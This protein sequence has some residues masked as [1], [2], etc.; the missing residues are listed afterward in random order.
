MI[1][2]LHDFI[3]KAELTLDECMAGVKLMPY[4]QI[5]Q[6]WTPEH[7]KAHRMPDILGLGP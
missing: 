5:D 2:H 7:N 4:N 3:G 1:R 6:A